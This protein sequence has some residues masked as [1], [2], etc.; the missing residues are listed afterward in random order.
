MHISYMQIPK[1]SLDSS[2]MQPHACHIWTISNIFYLCHIWTI[3]NIF[4]LQA[5]VTSMRCVGEDGYKR[6]SRGVAGA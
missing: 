1:V 5:T 3:S 4:Y 2:L 6:R